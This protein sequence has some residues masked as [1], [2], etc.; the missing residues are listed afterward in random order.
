[1]SIKPIY[2]TLISALFLAGCGSEIQREN[3]QI[4]NLTHQVDIKLK[5]L[6]EVA[7]EDAEYQNYMKIYNLNSLSF[8]FN[9][10]G[11]APG[12]ENETWKLHY[13]GNYSGKKAYYLD[14]DKNNQT[15]YFNK[16]TSKVGAEYLLEEGV[17]FKYT[18]TDGSKEWSW[19][20]VSYKGMEG[21]N[22][23][24]D[25]I[26]AYCITMNDDWSYRGFLGYYDTDISYR[27]TDARLIR[28][29]GAYNNHGMFY[30][31]SDNE[32]FYIR[33]LNKNYKQKENA[34]F[35]AY[36]FSIN[37]TNYTIENNIL[38]NAEKKEITDTLLYESHDRFNIV[39]IPKSLLAS[40]DIKLK[41]VVIRDSSWGTLNSYKYKENSGDDKVTRQELIRMIKN[42]ED[43]SQVDVSG[44]T[45]MN[46]LF[47]GKR[48]KYDITG[49]D[50]SNVTNMSEMFYY[51]ARPFAYAQSRFNQP[52]GNWDVS[53][54]VD[55]RSMFRGA[56]SFNQPIGDWDVSKVTSMDGMF[57][58][59]KSFN[60]PIGN[61]DVSKVTSMAEMF[62][63]A[64]F[65]QPIGD[66]D[67]SK[68]TNMQGMFDVA[69]RFNQPI[70]NWDVSNVTNMRSM[71][72]ST[73]FNQPIG[74]WDVSN[75]TDMTEMFE[76]ASSFNQ[77]IG[78]WDVSK[79][80]SMQGMFASPY[81][82][83]TSSFNQPIGDWDVS[84]VIN[85]RG[86]FNF[87][88]SFNQPIGDWDV[89]KVANMQGMFNFAK[90]FNQPIGNWNVSKVTTFFGFS[91][92]SSLEDKNIPV[93]LLY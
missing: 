11:L 40:G 7:P 70:G 22:N 90:S 21:F 31:A 6:R 41:K 76:Y 30:T 69:V 19:E 49:W 10:S 55:M 4:S 57:I 45:D 17:L 27:E 25:S 42:D 28:D 93:A 16:W 43:Y 23:N 50:V 78:N 1:M 79:V 58:R 91:D 2:L 64:R 71:F 61:W 75:V 48:V 14:T 47:E 77:S 37:G 63:A 59:T 84:K 13:N 26:L 88:I 35:Y 89:S 52:I 82:F 56:S 73:R 18:G 92:G 34:K 67:V 87:A 51:S 12:D 86:M 3:S 24:I 85:M 33:A 80:T 39:I 74:N 83:R 38:F 44:I 81:N 60:Q 5:T 65:N 15:G 62:N 72:I 9:K 8:N 29:E 66:W 20:I 68:V 53:K 32:D 46:S 54:V 36:E